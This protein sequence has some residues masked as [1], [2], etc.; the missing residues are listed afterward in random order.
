MHCNFMRWLRNVV[1]RGKQNGA[2]EH[3]SAHADI[4]KYSNT[5]H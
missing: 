5:D 3:K 2:L 4:E 1:P